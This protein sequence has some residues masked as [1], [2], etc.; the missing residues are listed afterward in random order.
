MDI[1]LYAALIFR[2]KKNNERTLSV[3]QT[4]IQNMFSNAIMDSDKTW[5][6]RDQIRCEFDLIVCIGATRYRH[7]LRDRLEHYI[8]IYKDHTE[9][10]FLYRS[11]RRRKKYF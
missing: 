8:H 6:A 7:K 1:Q 9:L 5:R 2:R 3:R 4:K 10:I 11:F